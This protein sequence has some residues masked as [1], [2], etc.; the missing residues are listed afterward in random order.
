MSSSSDKNKRIAKNT[1]FLYIRMFVILAVSVYTSRVVLD[2]L[3]A[4]DY[5]LYNIVGG[6][7]GMLGFL[8][9]TLAS[10]TSRYITYALGQG[11]NDALKDTFS[12]AFWI[13]V[14]L[15]GIVIVLLESGGLWLIYNKLIIPPDRLDA[16]FWVFQMSII[17]CVVSITQVPY[18]S[19]V[20]AHEQMGVYAY[21]G[22][23]EA[24]AKLVVAYLIS[25][26]IWDK[27]IFYAFLLMTVQI[28]V[29]VYYRFYCIRHYM[30][31]RIRRI[32]K[33]SLFKSLLGFSGLTLTANIAEIL[34]KQGV[35][36]L[37]NLFFQPAIV[38]AQAVG[39]QITNVLSQFVNNIRTAANPQIIKYYASGD[40]E[41][42]KKL[43]LK[44]TIYIYYLLLLL[45]LPL[46]LLM[47]PILNLWLVKV[48]PYTCVFSQF[49]IAQS[50]LGN[51]NASFYVP[52]LA[53]GKLAKNSIYAVAT[54]VLQFVILYVILKLGGN[55][56]WVPWILTLNVVIWSFWIKPSILY[57]D[58]HYSFKELIRCYWECLKVTI[59]PLLI[60]I[61]MYIYMDSTLPN[62]IIMLFASI[63]TIA[64][65]EIV[66][67]N[68]HDRK[69]LIEIAYHK[70]LKR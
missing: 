16:C 27:L 55:V 67:M 23:Y 56:M 21:V 58:V 26:T 28:S 42:S 32:L 62:H 52:M 19:A 41:L 57:Q 69:R 37:I 64:L 9:A 3:G 14:A 40:Y 54:C 34:S 68:K 50:I 38:A 43:T 30:E 17:T 8:N 11:D 66:L 20:I 60:L 15:A 7:V 44:S 46:I 48:P 6:V 70:I 31:C 63:S 5:G 61:P 4:D 18:N 53:S 24:I 1:I 10:S 49:I 22:I 65:S 33:K 25:V 59:F 29:A 12:T 51:W 45:G 35:I 13:H 47:D 2:K 39:N 36:V